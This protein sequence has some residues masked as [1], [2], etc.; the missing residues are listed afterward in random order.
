MHYYLQIKHFLWYESAESP[1]PLAVTLCGYFVSQIGMQ[2]WQK[3]VRCSCVHRGN[4]G[5]T[6]FRHICQPGTA[7]MHS[8]LFAK[9]GD[10]SE[11]GGQNHE[12]VWIFAYKARRLFCS[13]A[14]V[15]WHNHVCLPDI[16]VV[17][18][19]HPKCP[20]V[21]FVSWDNSCG[22]HALAV[23]FG[24][25]LAFF[26]CSLPI[27]RNSPRLVVY[28]PFSLHRL[29]FRF[30]L[31]GVVFWHANGRE[32]WFVIARQ[33]GWTPI[34]TECRLSSFITRW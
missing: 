29:T 3:T 17:Q 6:S 2:R 34:W 1:L 4:L 9:A 33:T 16:Y 14:G 26:R 7:S 22:I 24:A 8:F 10:L 15:L 31:Q 20:T 5:R 13:A 23:M 12:Q 27:S 30:W 25:V 28:G 21:C 18:A 19:A 11:S 32:A